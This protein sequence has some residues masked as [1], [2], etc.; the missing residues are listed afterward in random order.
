MRAL[1][2]LLDYGRVSQVKGAGC[3]QHA[4]HRSSLI[5][6]I[7]SKEGVKWVTMEQIC[8]DFK[9]KNHPP[10]G[11]LLPAEHGAILKDPSECDDDL[12]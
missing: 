6:Y 7:S 11:A 4:D 3:V 10:K 8:D 9:G 1:L 2:T 12:T 5:E